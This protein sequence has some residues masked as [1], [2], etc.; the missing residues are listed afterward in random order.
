MPE[1]IFQKGAEYHHVTTNAPSDK[2]F[3][4]DWTMGKRLYEIGSHVVDEDTADRQYRFLDEV[5]AMRNLSSDVKRAH[6]ATRACCLLPGHEEQIG[7][8]HYTVWGLGLCA[9][10]YRFMRAAHLGQSAEIAALKEAVD[11]S[12]NN[13]SFFYTLPVFHYL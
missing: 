9:L 7:D 12:L 11:S 5:D 8:P 13:H 10:G 1:C 3:V 6:D 4:K 2:A